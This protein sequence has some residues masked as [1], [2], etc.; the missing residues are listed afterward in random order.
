MGAYERDLAYVHDA[1][2]TGFIRKAAP[3]LMGLLR[4][5]GVKNGLV[6]DA[7]C[8]SGVW[9]RELTD[10]G[11]QVLGIDISPEMIRLA[12]EHAPKAKFRAESFLNADLPPCDAVTSIGECVN[13]A[14]DPKNGKKGLARFFRRVHRALRVG[15]VFVFDIVEPGVSE[16][17]APRRFMEGPDWAIFLEVSEDKV[18]RTLTRRIITFRKIGKVYRRSDETHKLYLY[19]SAELAAELRRAGFDAQVLKGYGRFRFTQAHAA[20]VAR[21]R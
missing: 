17:S 14:F 13:Y 1:G 10:R 9:A 3:G 16:G 4:K 19:S 11:F 21:K 20:L 15:G 2:F 6:V 8:G 18:R 12:R 7:G 5:S